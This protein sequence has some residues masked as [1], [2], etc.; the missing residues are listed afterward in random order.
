MFLT[1]IYPSRERPIPG[2][3][4][5]LIA[6]QLA[7]ERGRLMWRGEQSDLARVLAANTRDG[8]VVIIMGAGDITRSGPELLSL[9]TERK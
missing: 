4:S 8:D 1:E 6:D 3:T 7:V 2:V 5:S 9:L